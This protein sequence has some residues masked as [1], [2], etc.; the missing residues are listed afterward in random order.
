MTRVTSV[1]LTT[2]GVAVVVDF[3]VEQLFH[4]VHGGTDFDQITSGGVDLLYSLLRQPIN[5]RLYLF[6]K[7]R[8]QIQNLLR[9]P[10]TSY[11]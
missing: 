9:S 8:N 7:R 11:F 2:D 5:Y 1:T 10:P 6:R 4:E 3:G